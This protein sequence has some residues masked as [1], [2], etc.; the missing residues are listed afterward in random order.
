MKI[1]EIIKRSADKYPD[2]QAIIDIHGVLD[3]RTLG[4]TIDEMH[5]Q[6]QALG[7]EEGERVALMARNGRDFII[8]AF[9]IIAWRLRY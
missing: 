8:A 2:C 3:Y 4:H 9:G 6:L 5:R 7:L 1:Q